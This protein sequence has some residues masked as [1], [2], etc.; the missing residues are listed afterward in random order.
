MSPTMAP[1]TAKLIKQFQREAPV[2]VIGIANAYGI[3]VWRD[4]L[5]DGVSGK[6]LRDPDNGGTSGYS[7]VVND[8]EPAVRQRFTIA[9][10]IAHY[11]LH[12]ELIGSGVEDDALYRSRLSNSREAAANNL[13]AE[14]LMPYELLRNLQRDGI[15]DIAELAKRLQ[16]SQPALKIRTGVPVVD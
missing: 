9:H 16:V 1:T 11:L 10:E 2:D 15:T 4:D 14:I 12:R 8:S 5:P 13:A 7:I 6:I 3:N